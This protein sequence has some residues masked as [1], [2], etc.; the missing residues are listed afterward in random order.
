L[1]ETVLTTESI[2][3]MAEETLEVGEMLGL[4]VVA[5]RKNAIKRIA[6]SLQNARV[7]QPVHKTRQAV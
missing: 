5:N 3:K 1:S 2:R 6:Q 4:K 7:L